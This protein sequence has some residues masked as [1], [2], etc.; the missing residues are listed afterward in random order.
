MVSCVALRRP[1]GNSLQVPDAACQATDPGHHEGVARKV[2]QELKFGPPAAART[3]GLFGTD[4]V[5]A[6]RLQYAA[7]IQ[8]RVDAHDLGRL[9]TTIQGVSTLTAASIIANTGDPVR[10][11]NALS[12]AA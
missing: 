11:P 1:A 2:E 6:S 12:S 5:T 10:F 4:Y 8:R 3:A 9:F 7:N